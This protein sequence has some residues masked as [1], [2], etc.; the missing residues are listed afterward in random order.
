MQ[1]DD[2]AGTSKGAPATEKKPTAIEST[3]TTAE[4]GG[5]KRR[6]QSLKPQ[7][8]LVKRRSIKPSA[9]LPAEEEEA[10]RTANN[11][12]AAKLHQ[13]P[14]EADKVNYISEGGEGLFISGDSNNFAGLS[15]PEPSSDEDEEEEQ[16][17]QTKISE[18]ERKMDA[19]KQEVAPLIQ[20]LKEKQQARKAKDKEAAYAA[21]AAEQKQQQEQ[22]RLQPKQ[23]KKM[24]HQ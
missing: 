19:L 14:L 13:K 4:M 2:I 24:C 17:L 8:N 23:R 15:S 5:S 20:L 21:K 16:I 3:A 6:W 1:S 12:A 9:K 22:L 11:E 10:G 7:P 18:F